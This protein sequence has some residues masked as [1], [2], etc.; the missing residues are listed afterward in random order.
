MNTDEIIKNKI[1]EYEVH[2][3][4]YRSLVNTEGVWLFL[5]TLGCWGVGVLG[6]WSSLY[7]ILCSCD[8]L[9][10]IYLSYSPQIK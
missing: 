2:I 1:L 10:L 5:A 6:R 4:E 3:D 8:N 7:S 9:H